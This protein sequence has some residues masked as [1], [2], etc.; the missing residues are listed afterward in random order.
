MKIIFYILCL[1]CTLSGCFPTYYNK[2]AV[3]TKEALIIKD[4][5]TVQKFYVIAAGNLALRVISNNFYSELVRQLMKTQTEA[6]FEFRKKFKDT[7][8]IDVSV[9]DDRVFDGYLVISEPKDAKINPYTKKTEFFLGYTYGNEYT[10]T[11]KVEFYYSSKKLLFTA[12]ME[13]NFDPTN[14]ALYKKIIKQ[15]FAELTDNNILLL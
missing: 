13:L 3:T 1:V 4:P 10:G 8:P 5:V 6:A 9:P 7:D 14:P 15:L 12:D 11:I 2:T